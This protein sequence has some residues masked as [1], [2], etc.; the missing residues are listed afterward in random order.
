MEVKN[1]QRLQANV[2]EYWRRVPELN[3][4]QVIAEFLI[5]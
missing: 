3:I 4:D 5:Q 1:K 2:V